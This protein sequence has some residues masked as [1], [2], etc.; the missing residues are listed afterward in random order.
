MGRKRNFKHVLKIRKVWIR[1]SFQ[2]LLQV[3]RCTQ[4]KSQLLECEATIR[5]LNVQ[6]E[7]L[8]VQLKQTQTGVYYL[9]F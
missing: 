6:V 7:D 4:L 2:H 5:K 8:K 3:E 9:D 1:F